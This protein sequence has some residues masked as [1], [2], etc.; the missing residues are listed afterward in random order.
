MIP[1]IPEK[2]LP[3]IDGVYAYVVGLLNMEYV[4]TKAFD[5]MAIRIRIMT[6]FFFL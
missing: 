3:E 2:L 5:F 6:F 4:K 1:E